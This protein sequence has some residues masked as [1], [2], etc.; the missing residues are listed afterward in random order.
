LSICEEEKKILAISETR[1][2][3]EK[4]DQ[5]RVATSMKGGLCNENFTTLLNKF[6]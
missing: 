5:F 6:S 4:K 3:E 2:F 1:E